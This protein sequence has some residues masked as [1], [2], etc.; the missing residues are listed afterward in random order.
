MPEF[1]QA[2]ELNSSTTHLWLWH[3]LWL[4]RKNPESRAFSSGALPPVLRPIS[5]CHCRRVRV[6]VHGQMPQAPYSARTN[7]V[8]SVSSLLAV[9]S[10]N[11]QSPPIPIGL[12]PLHPPEP[13][14]N[15]QCHLP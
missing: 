4:R 11:P 13:A 5:P 7:E 9:R 3:K 12:R 2:L 15:T 10:S 1:S 14:R 6:P 8:Q